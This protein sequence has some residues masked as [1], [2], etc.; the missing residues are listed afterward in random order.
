MK[1]DFGRENGKYGAG[2]LGIVDTPDALYA[3]T[4]CFRLLSSVSMLPNTLMCRAGALLALLCN[5][6][7]SCTAFDTCTS[8]AYLRPS[9]N[10]CCKYTLCLLEAYVTKKR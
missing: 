9:L 5:M 10:Y 1:Y 2:G 8:T 3:S 6:L 7:A 4:F